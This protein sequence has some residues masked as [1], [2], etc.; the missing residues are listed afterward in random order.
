MR[1]PDQTDEWSKIDLTIATHNVFKGK[2]VSTCKPE[3]FNLKARR[4]DLCKQ[5]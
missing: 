3:R 5:L 1:F 4:N 2:K